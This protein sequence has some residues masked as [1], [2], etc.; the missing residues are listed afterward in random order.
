MIEYLLSS[1]ADAESPFWPIVAGTFIGAV[2][3]FF[4]YAILEERE[5]G[6]REERD[7]YWK[8]EDE[9]LRG[10]RL[11]DICFYDLELTAEQVKGLYDLPEP[12]W[13]APWLPM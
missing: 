11:R 13:R 2:C 1:W 12:V 7:A 6:W 9:R 4:C 10:P 5:R 8:K 3:A